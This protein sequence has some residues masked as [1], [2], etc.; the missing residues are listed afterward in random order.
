MSTFT[1]ASEEDDDFLISQNSRIPQRDCRGDFSEPTEIQKL[2]A[3]FDP[4][5][6]GFGILPWP[7][8]DQPS[9]TR[10]NVKTAMDFLT[11]NKYSRSQGD[12]K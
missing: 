8:T 12:K 6:I 1:L 2:H 7:G 5:K 4:G 10:D 11:G 9:P 3:R